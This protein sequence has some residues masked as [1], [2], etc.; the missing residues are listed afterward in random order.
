MLRDALLENIHRAQLNPLEE[1]AAYQQLL[2]EFGATHEE[3]ASRIGRSR[4]QVSN[5]IRLLN[6]PVAGAAP[7]R[8]RRAVGRPRPRAARA[9]RRRTRRTSWPAGSSPRACRCGPP[10]SWSRCT[11]TG[12]PRRSATRRAAGAADH[13]AG[14]RRAG[15]Q[16]VR[17]VRHPGPGRARPAQGQDH[18]RVRLGRRPGAHRRGDGTAAGDPFRRGRLPTS[19]VSRTPHRTSRRRRRRRALR[20]PR[21]SDGERTSGAGW[22]RLITPTGRSRSGMPK[23]ARSGVPPLGGHAEEAARPARRRPRRAASAARPCRCRRPSTG[24]ASGPRRGRSSP[25]PARRSGRDRPSC[26]TEQTISTG[27]VC[28]PGQPAVRLARFGGGR[29]ERPDRRYVVQHQEVPALGV[30]GRRRPDRQVEQL[31]DRLARRPAG[32][33]RR[34]GPSGA[35]RPRRSS[36]MPPACHAH[37]RGRACRNAHIGVPERRLV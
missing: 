18:R 25:C 4:S 6:L 31:V 22:P 34:C 24:P 29:P 10:R 16:A 33:G 3:L 12:T 8:R 17:H 23:A 36:S 15:R 1:A 19:R 20:R 9:R 11:G 21:R 14:A 5:T 7:G 26:R 35:A 37:G 28:M 30:A 2:E 27:A 13:R 32:R